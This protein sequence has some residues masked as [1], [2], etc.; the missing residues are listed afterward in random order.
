MP[1]YQ[2]LF[3]G[4]LSQDKI[5]SGVVLRKNSFAVKWV[6]KNSGAVE[7]NPVNDF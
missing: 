2:L 3:Y 6:N 7:K 5:L 1:L 4:R